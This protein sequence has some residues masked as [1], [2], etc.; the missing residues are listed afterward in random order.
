[1]LSDVMLDVTP[2]EVT[3]AAGKGTLGAWRALTSPGRRVGI[4]NDGPSPACKPKSIGVYM[5]RHLSFIDS[6]KAAGGQAKVR[7]TLG[8]SDCVGS[9]GGL[10]KRELWWN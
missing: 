4:D 2:Q 8:K 10:R 9:Q 3:P 1:M 5:S 6:G 7:T